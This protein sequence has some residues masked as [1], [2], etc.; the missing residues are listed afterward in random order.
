[1]KIASIIL[2]IVLLTVPAFGQTPPPLA[3]V[4]D[5]T[6][7]A[8]PANRTIQQD[9]RQ[10]NLV[11]ER[12]PSGM[13]VYRE[14]G[15]KKLFPKGE[16]ATPPQS[17]PPASFATPEDKKENCKK[18]GPFARTVAEIRQK[19]ISLQIAEASTTI[20][21]GKNTTPTGLEFA[22]DIVRVIYANKLTTENAAEIIV[23]TCETMIFTAELMEQKKQ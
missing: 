1:M 20:M 11:P 12:T 13:T 14:A 18:L 9:H 10:K 23:A 7:L 5:V 6:Q 2:A 15:T 3:P 8:N 4:D 22:K 19:G 21:L 17:P 16:E